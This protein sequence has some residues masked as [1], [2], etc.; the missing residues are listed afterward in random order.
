VLSFTEF[1]KESLATSKRKYTDKYPERHIYQ[2]ARIRNLVIKEV[3]M[4]FKKEEQLQQF[5]EKNNISPTWHRSN[6]K[7]FFVREIN[8]KRVISLSK[9][10]KKVLQ[11]LNGHSR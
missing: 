9:F 7:Y 2:N 10:G 5:L 3:G 11:I 6:K 8:G 4:G 1:I